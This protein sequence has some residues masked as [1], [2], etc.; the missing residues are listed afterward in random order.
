CGY[1][2]ATGP[3]F[4]IH[5]GWNAMSRRGCRH[6][7]RN[8]AFVIPAYGVIG[9]PALCGTPMP[10]EH[11]LAVLAVMVPVDCLPQGV[12]G[13]GQL[14]LCIVAVLE[15][16][17]DGDQRLGHKRCLDDVATI[18]FVAKRT[19]LARRAVEPMRPC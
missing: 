7:V 18:I 2:A 13:G 16:L 15:I 19:Y 3:S 4:V 14:P 10:I 9:R 5:F 1:C 12:R 6:N 11:V 17:A 8:K